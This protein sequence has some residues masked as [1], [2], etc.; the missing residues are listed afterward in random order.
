MVNSEMGWNLDAI[1]KTE[2]GEKYLQKAMELGRKDDWIYSE[3]GYS[4]LRNNKAEEGIEYF[5]KL[6]LRKMMY[7]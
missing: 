1:G 2:E 4:R 5:L 6:E 7:G 3:I